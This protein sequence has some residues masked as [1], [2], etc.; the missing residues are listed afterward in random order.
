MLREVIQSLSSVAFDGCSEEE[1]RTVSLFFIIQT[2]IIVFITV[3][4]IEN[5]Y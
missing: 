2:Y 5:S 3:K 4:R 1:F